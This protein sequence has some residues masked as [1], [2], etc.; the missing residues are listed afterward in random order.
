MSDFFREVDEDFRR[1]QIINIWKRY[2]NWI[3]GAALL[4]ILATA[5]WRANE[6]YRMKADE[7]AGAKFEAASQLL[8]D[9]KTAE[10]IAAFDA[11]SHD[12][13]KGYAA[14]S[15]LVAADATAAKDPKAGLQ[16]YD[17]LVADAAFDE[18]LKE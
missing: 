5:G 9:G 16:A 8:R 1:D 13:P 4:V 15:R 6:Y 2:Q 3:I 14:L 17:A 18:T 7:A 10:A 11:M 12:A